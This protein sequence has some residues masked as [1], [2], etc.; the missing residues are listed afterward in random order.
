MPY[1]VISGFMSGI[2]CNSNYSANCAFWGRAAPKGWSVLGTV[3]AIPQLLA[4]LICRSDF[5]GSNARDC[6][7]AQKLGDWVHS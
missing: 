2:G 4:M 3:A 1:S 5:R 7:H 6:L